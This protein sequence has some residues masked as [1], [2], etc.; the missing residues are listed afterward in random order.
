M[1]RRFWVHVRPTSAAA[2]RPPVPSPTAITAYRQSAPW[3][4][5][6]CRCSTA[7][8]R[9]LN[10]THRSTRTTVRCWWTPTMCS[11]PVSP[12]PSRCLTRSSF[13][14]VTVRKGCASTAEI[15]P[16]S[17]KKPERCSTRQALPTSRSLPPT[18]WTSTSSATCNYKELSSTALA[19]VSG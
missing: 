4:T 16:T 11:N 14:W 19:S 10:P 18:R 17:P 1:M 2:A 13:R 7:N 5:A 3:R 8:M 9:R 6:G 15:L 12:T